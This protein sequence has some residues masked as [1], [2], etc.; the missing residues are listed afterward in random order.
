MNQSLDASTSDVALEISTATD[1]GNNVI[2]DSTVTEAADSRDVA[3]NVENNQS[4]HTTGS[5]TETSHD[6]F[7]CGSAILL[8]ERTA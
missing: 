8:Q 2:G 6:V 7:R 1:T 4:S 5:E 3:T